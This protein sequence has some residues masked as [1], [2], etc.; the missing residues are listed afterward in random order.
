MRYPRG[1]E[2]LPTC[3]ECGGSGRMGSDHCSHCNGTGIEGS[4]A[5]LMKIILAVAVLWGIGLIV[6]FT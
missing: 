2:P 3:K 6:I 4:P 1:V 5:T